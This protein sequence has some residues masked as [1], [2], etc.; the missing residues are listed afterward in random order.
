MKAAVFE[1]IKKIVIKNDYPDP[2]PGPDDVIVKVH[3]CGICGTDVSNF[4]VKIY[5]VPL[6]MGHEFAGEVVEIGEHIT[7]I[8]VG[9]EV[10][11][12][13]VS[14][15]V[16]TGQLDGMG[17]FQDGG[18]AELVRVPK[19]YLFKI[20][21]N[22]STKEA[23]MIESFANAVRGTRLSEIGPKEKIAIIGGGNIGLCFMDYLIAE[24]KPKYVIVIEPQEFLREKAIEFGADS[25]FPPNMARIKRFTK[26]NGFPSFVFDCAGN[27]KSIILAIDLIKRGGTI[28]LEGV[29]KGS[30]NFPI[31][32]INSKEVCLKGCLG[33]D[34]EDILSAINFFTQKKVNAN[35][36]I[37]QIVSLDDI[38]ETFRLFLESRERKFIKIA[39]KPE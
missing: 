2:I 38:Q 9:D 36:F 37:S 26:K 5:Q 39:V 33:H 8:S 21:K 1:E 29:H 28:L 3:Y 35:K 30:I 32:L 34:R 31:F 15:D 10:C 25:T 6:I 14:L 4:K 20:P 16:S 11:G 24:K 18:F 19:K 7:D 17:I 27:E 12:I 13:N 22:I 23:I